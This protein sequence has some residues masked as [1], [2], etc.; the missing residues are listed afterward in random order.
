[1][2]GYVVHEDKRFELLEGMLEEIG[3]C[4]EHSLLHFETFDYIV[5]GLKGPDEHFRYTENGITRRLA[6]HFFDS[7]KPGCRLYTFKRQPFLEKM[8][9]L[10]HLSYEVFEEHETVVLK[11]ADITSEA[12]IAWL[13]CHCPV[14]L[15]ESEITIFGYGHL[16]RSLV[17]YLHPITQQLHVVCRNAQLDPDIS[18]Y[19]LA[20][21]FNET[22]FYQSRI[23]LNT[24]PQRVIDSTMLA[25]MP[26]DSILLDLASFPYGFDLKEAQAANIKAEIL[27]GLPGKVELNSAARIL[28]EA[29]M[30]GRKC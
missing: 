8:A 9:R 11:N 2:R 16:G 14:M 18:P 28:F 26:Q 19:A 23:Y 10:H 4:C 22:P 25:Q 13:I 1:M 27:S 17:K 20:H 5:F 24:V 15:Q 12:T 6:S 3:D 7:L 21:R 29:I 30:E